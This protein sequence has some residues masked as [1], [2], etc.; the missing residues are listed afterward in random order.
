MGFNAVSPL[1]PVGVADYVLQKSPPERIFN[2]Y[3]FSGYF[4]WRFAGKRKLYIDLHNVYP[5]ELLSDYFEIIG[6]TERGKKL[7]E[8]LKINTVIAGRWSTDGRFEPLVKYLDKKDSGWEKVYS[9]GLNNG[10]VWVRR[11]PK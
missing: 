11:K 6:R 1:L 9:G 10:G 2:D 7:L 3:L 4:H 5:P 8:D